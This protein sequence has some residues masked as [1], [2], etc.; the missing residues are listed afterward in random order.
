MT[1]FSQDYQQLKQYVL[2][3][4]DREDYADTVADTVKSDLPELEDRSY[5]RF[6]RNSDSGIRSDSSWHNPYEDH[7]A[8]NQ[9][10]SGTNTFTP[11]EDGYYLFV[12]NIQHD[13]DQGASDIEYRLRNLTDDDTEMGPY[14]K[15]RED[16]PVDIDFAF[17]ARLFADEETEIQYQPAASGVTGECECSITKLL[18]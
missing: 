17:V 1:N 12:G 4:L 18:A 5:V 11:N 8:D 6:Y 7:N 3:V 2:R 9:G 16:N 10:E 14:I 15:D 13:F